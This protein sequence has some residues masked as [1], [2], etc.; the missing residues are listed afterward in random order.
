M[1]AAT[2]RLQ[3]ERLDLAD[4]ASRR[5]FGALLHG[6]FDL[7]TF[8]QRAIAGSDDGGMVDEDILGA[9]IGGDEPETL[10]VTEPLD[11]ALFTV[12]HVGNS[13]SKYCCLFCKTAGARVPSVLLDAQA[14][15]LIR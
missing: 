6:V 5:A 11:S 8:G 13:L 1:V 7:V 3:N 12:R 9:G 14:H 4:V 2:S 15:R 10:L